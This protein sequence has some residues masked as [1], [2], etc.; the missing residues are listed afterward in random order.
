MLVNKVLCFAIVDTGNCL[1]LLDTVMAKALHLPIKQATGAEF[2]C[3]LV[4]G[5]AC[6]CPYFWIVDSPLHVQV[7]DRVFVSLQHVQVVK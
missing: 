6:S 1:T 5:T 3:Y 7:V 4:L 2:G